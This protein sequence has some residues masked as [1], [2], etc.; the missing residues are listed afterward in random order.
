MELKKPRRWGWSKKHIAP[1]VRKGCKDSREAVLWIYGLHSVTFK[2]YKNSVS[3][4]FAYCCST[5]MA[6]KERNMHTQTATRNT[7]T[8]EKTPLSTDGLTSK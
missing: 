5:T 2:S 1:R 7:L 4:S 8:R 6:G 3:C